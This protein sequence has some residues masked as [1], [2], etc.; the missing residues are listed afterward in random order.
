M[1][2]NDQVTFKVTIG[3]RFLTNYI[4]RMRRKCS[5]NAVNNNCY[6]PYQREFSKETLFP[7]TKVFYFCSSDFLLDSQRKFKYNL[8]DTQHDS[9]SS[10]CYSAAYHRTTCRTWLSSIIF[11]VQGTIPR[12]NKN[13]NVYS[14]RSKQP[15]YAYGMVK[16]RRQLLKKG[17]KFD[18]K[19]REWVKR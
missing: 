18:P 17:Y 8:V 10:A 13:P 3:R 11:I 9:R 19:T 2:G 5:E 4:L 6:F 12:L 15:G 1:E 14:G 7:I 16:R